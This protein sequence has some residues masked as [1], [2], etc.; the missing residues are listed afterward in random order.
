MK[1]VCNEKS[2]LLVFRALPSD[3]DDDNDDDGPDGHDDDDGIDGVDD[4]DDDI[5]WPSLVFMGRYG[6]AGLRW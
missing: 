5:Y 6:G 3:D 2:S 4:D 1:C